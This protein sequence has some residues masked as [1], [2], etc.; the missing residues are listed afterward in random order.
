MVSTPDAVIQSD[1]DIIGIASPPRDCRGCSAITLAYAVNL[2]NEA[3]FL[4]QLLA[5]VPASITESHQLIW[6]LILTKNGDEVMAM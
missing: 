1:S 2:S 5:E 6:R 4:V 3:T